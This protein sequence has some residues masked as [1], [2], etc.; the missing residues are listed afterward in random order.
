MF[1]SIWSVAFLQDDS[2]RGMVWSASRLGVH[3]KLQN[4]AGERSGR[5]RMGP[6]MV[7]LTTSGYFYCYVVIIIDWAN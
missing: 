6:K 1:M 4:H 7:S 3:G 2:I 5:R